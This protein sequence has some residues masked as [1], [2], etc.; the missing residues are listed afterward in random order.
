MPAVLIADIEVTDVA[1]EYV[2]ETDFGYETVTILPE[3]PSITVEGARS[4]TSE[5]TTS[6]RP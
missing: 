2:E 4:P 5:R 3:G 1:A 6:P